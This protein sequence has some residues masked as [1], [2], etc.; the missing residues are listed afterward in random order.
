MVERRSLQAIFLTC[1]SV[2]V[3]PPRTPAQAEMVRA[4]R[5]HGNVIAD[6]RAGRGAGQMPTLAMFKQT[7]L[8]RRGSCC[9]T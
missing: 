9:E 7:I 3:A 2:Q 6:H 5:E 1:L 4:Q 8:I